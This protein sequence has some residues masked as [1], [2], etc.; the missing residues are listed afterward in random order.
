MNMDGVVVARMPRPLVQRGMVLIRVQYSLISVGT[1]VA[2]L[3]PASVSAPDVTRDRA[4]LE[5]ARL[6]RHYFRASLR[7]PRKAARRLSQIAERRL[8]R[9]RRSPRTPR[10][11]RRRRAG[12]IG[13][14]RPG[15]GDRLLGRR[16]KSSRSATGIN[17]LAAGDL[18]ACAGAGQANHAEYVT[19]AAQP[20]LPR[21]AGLRSEARGV[22]HHRRHR[23]AGR[24]PR[25]AAA[26]RARVRHRPRP[27]RPDHRAAA[28][29]RRLPRDRPRSRRRRASSAR[30]RSACTRARA[31]P[32]AF[33]ALVRDLTGGR[34]ADRTLM[35]A[36]TKSNAVD[37]P[38]DGASRAPKGTVVIVGDVGLNVDRAVFYRKEI[39]LLMSTSYGPGRYDPA[40]EVE[41]HDYPYALRPL[42][43]ESEHAGV[44]RA[45]R[46]AAGRR[47]SR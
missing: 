10:R 21:P 41:G 3:R 47:S 1:E 35:T 7:D 34:G 28:A 23:A 46:R 13:P 2:P 6:A 38:R 14:Q 43:A 33:K 37:Q 45:G 29:S 42:D 11:S 32:D 40:Y 17:D 5:R 26:R 30:S 16:A 27:D 39:D 22:G 18:V 4:A 25:R 31:M 8:S 20:R 24:P 19:R 15:M 9:L 12:D 44:S 36:A